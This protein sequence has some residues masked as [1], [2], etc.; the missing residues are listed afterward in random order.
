L[1]QLTQLKLLNL[2]G[3]K[4]LVKLP[5]LPSSIAIIIADGCDKLTSIGDLSE[6]CEWLCFIS[7]DEST[8]IDGNRLLQSMLKVASCNNFCGF[9]IF[10]VLK[11]HV[12]ARVS[13]YIT[14]MEESS[15]DMRVVYNPNKGSGLTD[16]SNDSSEFTDDYAPKFSIDYNPKKSSLTISPRV[17]G[18]FGYY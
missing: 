9:L 1:S 18:K 3:C 7:L 2:S 14:I 6:N 5:E 10:A 17:Y 16:A 13:P 8:V 11:D 12:H 15:D 4:R